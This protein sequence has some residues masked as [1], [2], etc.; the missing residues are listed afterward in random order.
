M[1]RTPEQN[2]EYQRAYRERKARPK[3]QPEPRDQPLPDTPALIAT[4]PQTRKDAILAK[5]NTKKPRSS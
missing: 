4:M 1:P 3:D 5:I 2:R